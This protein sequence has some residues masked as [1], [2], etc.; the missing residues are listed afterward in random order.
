MKHLLI[1]FL[2][3]ACKGQI[4]KEDLAI[5]S[6]VKTLKF[7]LDN[8]IANFGNSIQFI[9]EN[10]EEMLMVFSPASYNLY[11]YN[12]E[13]QDLR[14]K[15][16]FEKEGPNGIGDS[17]HFHYLSQDSIFFLPKN[18]T[19]FYL[20]NLRGGESEIYRLNFSNENRGRIPLA[21]NQSTIILKGERIYMT[22]PTSYSPSLYHSPIEYKQI[23]K[24]CFQYIYDLKSNQEVKECISFPLEYSQKVYPLYQNFVSQESIDLG[25]IY[26]FSLLDSLHFFDNISKKI[27][28]TLCKTT[29]TYPKRH[30]VETIDEVIPEHESQEFSIFMNSLNY[31]NVIYDKY[32][33]QYYRIVEYPVNEDELNPYLQ[34]RTKP[35]G[36]I[37]LDSSRNFKQEYYLGYGNY[38]KTNIFVSKDGL[39][40]LNYEKILEDEYFITYD[41]FLL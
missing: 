6:K 31:G 13:T 15:F 17:H 4:S 20:T 7:Q 11:T 12:I 29:T 19:H 21:T 28:S 24:S 36:I 41:T 30:I 23:E 3:C 32:R 9:E 5:P 37:V 33:N 38:V 27:S 1:L 16:K 25:I 35:L 39:N 14:S 34:P 8:E 10:G 40:I 2:L 22:S 26:S 18:I